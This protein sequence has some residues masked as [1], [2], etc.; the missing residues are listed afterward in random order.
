[1]PL[2]PSIAASCFPAPIFGTRLTLGLLA[3][4]LTEHDL[5]DSAD[6][7]QI[8]AG[9]PWEVAP[10]RIEGIRVTHSLM[11]CLALAIETPIGTIIHT[12][13]FKIDNTPMEGEM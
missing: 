10:F 12:G 2:S 9:V 4:K 13:D 11:D 8:T 5:E 7:R 3:N 6:V 1:M